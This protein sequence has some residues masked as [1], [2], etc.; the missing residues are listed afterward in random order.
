MA[1]AD[2]KDIADKALDLVVYGPVGLALYLRDTAPH[3]ARLFV[4][5]RHPKLL[6][7]RLEFRLERH[8]RHPEETDRSD[9]L[10]VGFHDLIPGASAPL[11]S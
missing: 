6:L 11:G 1:D 9:L 7:Y 5:Y 8:A 4:A 3:F 10:R 2:R